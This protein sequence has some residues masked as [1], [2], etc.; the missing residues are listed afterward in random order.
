MFD[1]QLWTTQFVALDPSSYV[2]S[3]WFDDISSL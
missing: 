2:A 3:G 1:H